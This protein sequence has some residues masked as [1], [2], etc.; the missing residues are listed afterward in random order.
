VTTVSP[1]PTSIV[2]HVVPRG[3]DVKTYAELTHWANMPLIQP[4]VPESQVP[5]EDEVATVVATVAVV[6]VVLS[7][8]DRQMGIYSLTASV[9]TPVAFP[10]FCVT[11]WNVVGPLVGVL[12]ATETV[13]GLA[14]VT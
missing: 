12:V 1:L 13:L 10:L 6:V 3:Q 4:T 7:I 14:A 9:P 2:V 5:R 8:S 11:V